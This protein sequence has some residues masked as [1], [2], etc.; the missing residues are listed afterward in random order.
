M[1]DLTLYGDD[2][3]SNHVYNDAYFYFEREDRDYLYAL[4]RE[5]FLYTEAQMSRLIYDLR[6][7]EEFDD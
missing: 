2:E 3:L 1:I 4:I 7:E 5:Q 6:E